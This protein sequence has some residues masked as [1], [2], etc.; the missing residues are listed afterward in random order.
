MTPDSAALA[1]P[2][3]LPP[4]WDEMVDGRG[5]IRPHWRGIVGMLASLP[6]GGLADRARRLDRAF[7]EEGVVTILPADPGQGHVQRPWRC[8]P[9]PMVL[10]AAEFAALE[11]GLSQRAAL[12][13][14][15][16]ADLY[17]PQRLLAAGLIPP[18]LVYG[19]PGFLRACR[20]PSPPLRPIV[21]LLAAD[22]V[23]TP[24]GQWQVLADRAGAPNGVGFA[25]E[26]RRMVARVMPE[27]FRSV[28]VRQLRPFF[29]HWVDSLQRAAPSGAENPR[30][31]LLTQGAA[32]ETWF[33][34]VFLSRE[35]GCALVEGADLT[36]RDG[37][38]FLK[39]LK[40]LQRVH[41]L[42]RRVEGRLTDPLE[43]AS[44]STLGVPGLLDAMRAGGVRVVNDPGSHLAEAPALAAFLPKLAE[45]V[46]GE[47]LRLASVPTLWLGDA[48]SAAAVLAAPERW[49]IRSAVDG[50]AP[51]QHPSVMG[52]RARAALL[53]RIRAT[54]AAFA[55]T[56]AVRPSAA[57]ALGE[58]GLAPKEMV[59]RLFALA[60][61]A[62]T[63]RAMPGGLARLIGE[64][65]RLTGRLPKAGIAKDVWVLSED[66][67]DIVGPAA[68]ALPPLAI[69][70]ASGEL[71]SRVA[72]D[73]Y[74]LG[75]YVERLENAARLL[76]AVIL[77]LSRGWLLPRDLA[78]LRALAACLADAGIV[79]P[80]VAAAAPD[81]PA[82]PRAML[83]VCRPA[84][85]VAQVFDHVGRLTRGVRDRLTADMWVTMMHLAAEARERS[86]AA[87]QGLE[88]LN[89][90]AAAIM[91]FS[92]G[93]AGIA[94]ENMVRGGGWLFLDLG[95]RIERA[96]H[97]A[98][99][100]GRALD[101]PLPRV[102]AGLRL[103]VELC[104]SAI[105]YRSRYL[106]V[107][108]PAPVLDLV[109]ADPT[110][111][112]SFAYQ[113]D[114]VERRLAEVQGAPEGDLARSAGSLR[115]EA[116]AMVEAVSVAREPAAEAVLLP[117]QLAA[118]S[119]QVGVLSD[120]IARRYFSHVPAAQAVGVGEEQA[121]G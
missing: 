117:A 17:G 66:R 5:S 95:R 35:L 30:L 49:M 87:C 58:K 7:E 80:E 70:R 118:L 19:N 3:P 115:A 6:Q 31:A 57:P 41:V 14:E 107:L 119:H 104:D 45:H 42:L 81:G 23:R 76:R 108:Q 61:G 98:R 85:P 48:A 93:V 2:V 83:D 36:T 24:Q 12:L 13:S 47:R 109:L 46:L 90:A 50:A 4:F 114:A 68:F 40:G 102:E 73:L 37:Q 27:A 26:N 15:I 65:E 51:A 113:L 63:W 53:E 16:L 105:T 112:R 106:S 33:E 22:L 55:A 71:P 72:D 101:Q 78:E 121:A 94:A 29:D 64:G 110:N 28:Q 97:T 111:P 59:L 56:E 103:A 99:D 60:D 89:E 54:P 69:R 62:G 43:L 25:R 1:A 120:A 67:A 77:R 44:D 86:A 18:A 39:T 52:E 88:E 10:P 20:A 34:H 11:A 84:R 8:D 32:H 9:V 96:A 100:I 82:L 75:R 79:A 38:V 91:R 92:A 21:H 74:W 116:E